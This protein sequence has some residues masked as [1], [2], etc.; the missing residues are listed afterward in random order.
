MNF[1]TL[2]HTL[3]FLVSIGLS[4]N[5]YAHDPLVASTPPELPQLDLLEPEPLDEPINAIHDALQLQNITTA[6]GQ[7]ESN[8]HIEVISQ[9]ILRQLDVLAEIT[10]DVA[11]ILNNNQVRL[12]AAEKSAARTE[13]ASLGTMIG[14]MRY[15]AFLLAQKENFPALIKLIGTIQDNLTSAIKTGLKKFPH[16]EFDV[17][18]RTQ[19]AEPFDV[20]Q[21]TQ[22]LQEH[23]NTLVTLGQKAPHVG[24]S[25][26]NILY[27]K[28]R[29]LNHSY[30][31]VKKTLYAVGGAALVCW[32]MYRLHETLFMDKAAEWEPDSIKDPI[33]HDLYHTTR[34]LSA[35][36][37]DILDTVK[38]KVRSHADNGPLVY[39]DDDRLHPTKSF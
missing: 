31:I 37:K 12:T 21:L 33:K 18:T 16:T 17:T 36:E 2:Q 19:A 38:K 14:K 7:A 3:L 39:V 34:K 4:A 28:L 5:I 29:K 11:Q 26:L 32:G 15:S 22:Q 27:R 24:L 9:E 35:A 1:K 20:E 8:Q 30:G 10:S 6:M 23:N 13:L 25:S